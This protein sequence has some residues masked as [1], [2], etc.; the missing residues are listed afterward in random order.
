MVDSYI[1]YLRVSTDKQGVTGLGMDAQREAVARYVGARGLLLAE[2]VEVESGK[3]HTNRPQLLAA[4]AECRKRRAVLVIARLDRLARNVAFIANLMNSDVE[5]VAVDMPH[6]NRLTIHILAAVAEYERDLISQRTKAAMA[7][8]KARGIKLG[9]PRYQEALAKAREARGYR[10]APLEVLNLMLEW[11]GHGDVLRKIADRLNSLNIRTPQGFR[12]YASSVRV[13]LSRVTTEAFKDALTQDRIDATT[14]ERIDA[15][16]QPPNHRCADERNHGTTQERNRA[17]AQT[18]SLSGT[19]MPGI[20]SK[21]PFNAGRK[22][23]LEGG[24]PMPSDI[25]EAERMLD[26]FTSVGARTFDVT[27]TELEWPGHKKPK[28]GKTYS[29][30]ELRKLLPAMV[31][32]A[33]DRKPIPD[34]SGRV[35]YSGENLIVRPKGDV[36]FV[37]LDDLDAERLKRV[38]SAA[39]LIHSTS[40]GNHQAWIAVSG[41]EG[42]GKAFIRRVR[43]AIGDVDTSASGATRIAG[44]GNWKEKYLPEPPMVSIVSGIP[45]RIMTPDKL[46]TM[47]LLA[48]PEPAPPEI[49]KP[50]PPRVSARLNRRWPSYA[51]SLAGAPPNS[52]GTGPSRSHA[53]FVWCKTALKWGW[54]EE[55][56]LQKLLEV[57]EKARSLAENDPGYARVTVQNAA[58]AVGRDRQR[59]RA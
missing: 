26:L 45:G 50:A 21:M 16:T 29:P 6:A 19:G 18:S 38:Q 2:Y 12:W 14:E 1:S 23:I 24:M 10:P 36:V 4:I 22:A 40:P 37:Q 56:T 13:A 51:M 31:R 30:V 54:N 42:D 41:V 49:V 7:A 57:S 44:V 9:N 5:F 3:K 52:E 8:A 48:E 27:K 28:W 35:V 25:R 55:D 34:S 32:T 58:A 53:D 17:C 47:G 15:L 46:Q 11:R 59:S 20:P 39:F 33:D 43:K